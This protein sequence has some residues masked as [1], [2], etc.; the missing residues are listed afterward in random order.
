[1]SAL[2][3]AG[4]AA[5]QEGEKTVFYEV[6]TPLKPRFADASSIQP[7]DKDKKEDFYAKNAIDEDPATRWSSN[8]NEPQWLMIDLGE[9]CE[10]DRVM[11]RWESAYAASYN[12][13][14]STDKKTWTEAY[15]TQEGQGK[16]ETLTFKPQKARYIKINCLKRKGQWGFSIWDV[17]IYG[18][19]KLVLF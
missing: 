12:I 18:K 4:Y 16:T 11:I 6:Q 19:K 17:M 3:T 1:M 13:E 5:A 10:V 7:P 14:V 8:F 9:V 2:I 15:S